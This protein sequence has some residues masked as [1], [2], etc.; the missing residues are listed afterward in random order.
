[1]KIVLISSGQ[2]S[3]NPRLVKEADALVEAGYEVCVIYQYWNNWASKLDLSLLS[4]KKWQTIRVGGDPV[5]EKITYW[6]SRILFSVAKRLAASFS[7]KY[8]IAELAIGRCT[9]ALVDEA[10]K[11]R[12]D[13]YIAH[14]LG[15]LPAAIIAAKKNQAKCGFDA[16]DF[17]R[18]EISNERQNLDVRLKSFIEDK[19]LNQVDYLT[20]A[21]PLINQAYQNLYP[22]LKPTPLLNVFPKP[23]LPG[24]PNKNQT[25][26]K[27]FW[28]SQTIGLGRGLEHIVQALN[29]LNHPMIELHLLGNHNTTIK[30]QLC[31]STSIV[32]WSRN[33]IFF[34]QPIMAEEIFSFALQ[35]DVGLATESKYPFNR[36]ICL[37]NKIFTYIQSGLAVIATDT[38][39]QSKLLQEYPNSGFIYRNDSIVELKEIIMRYFDDRNLLNDN[40]QQNLSYASSTLNWDF[41]KNFFLTLVGQTLNKK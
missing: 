19:Y 15:A 1:M 16:E 30:N 21:S 26:L 13:L 39:A 28:F 5:K 9:F 25:T 14:N 41:E 6:A 3:L 18:N 31:L 20:T 23:N 4:S 40:Q 27:L 34:Y 22:K 35:F 8:K 17:H 2:P 32:N 24:K 37:T 11:N 36:D 10:K 7:L 38:T 33:N 29:E 12:A